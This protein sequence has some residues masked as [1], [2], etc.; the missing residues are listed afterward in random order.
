M[1]V[2]RNTS[3]SILK[4]AILAFCLLSLPTASAKKSVLKNIVSVQR[5]AGRGPAQEIPVAMGR[6]TSFVLQTAGTDQHG[7]T[8]CE[9]HIGQ[10]LR[11]VEDNAAVGGTKNLML[12]TMKESG[13]TID[14][15][16]RLEFLAKRQATEDL[17]SV[18]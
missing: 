7:V 14:S 5:R 13:G 8:I 10:K 17:L 1:S 4:K 12:E 2:V 18:K 16:K 3:M 15:S 9:A 11:R 6:A